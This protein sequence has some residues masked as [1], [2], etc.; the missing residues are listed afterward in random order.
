MYSRRSQRHGSAKTQFL[1]V[2]DDREIVHGLRLV[3]EGKGY[4]VVTA[5]DGMPR[6]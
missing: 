1:I 4:R 3:L 6:G 2:D 5:F